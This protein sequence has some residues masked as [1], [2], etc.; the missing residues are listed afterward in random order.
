MY[1][2]KY[3]NFGVDHFCIQGHLLNLKIYKFG[4]WFWE[5]IRL[6]MKKND[7]KVSYLFKIYNFSFDVSPSEVIWKKNQFSKFDVFKHNFEK[8]NVSNK[9]IMNCKVS[10]LFGIYNFSVGIYNFSIG[11]FSIGYCLKKFK[12]KR[13][14]KCP[15]LKYNFGGLNYLKWKKNKLQIYRSLQEL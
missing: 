14:S 5:P 3:F 4:K 9:N 11:H 6:Q 7:Y 15:N 1:L 10:Y 2:V 13:I 12:K 8:L